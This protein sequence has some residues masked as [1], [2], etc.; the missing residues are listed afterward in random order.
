MWW[1]IVVHG[2][3]G[4]VPAGQDIAVRRETFGT[5]L[6]RL[7]LTFL[8]RAISGQRPQSN[9]CIAGLRVEKVT[10]NFRAENRK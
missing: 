2:K 8:T 1:L 7:L 4:A 3:L 5:E 10:M 9:Y 6:V